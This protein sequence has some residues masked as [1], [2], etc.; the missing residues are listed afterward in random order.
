MYMSGNESKKKLVGPWQTIHGV[1]WIIGIYFLWTR[2][3]WWPGLL[4]LVGIS[5]LYEAIL[6]SFVPGAYEEEKPVAA[7]A[8]ERMVP[9][10]EVIPPPAAISTAP[11]Q[12][13]RIDLLPQVCPGCNAPV[14]SY[15]LKW[16]GVQ[17]ANCAYCGTNL[18]MNKA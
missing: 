6:R 2:G 1:I 8:P 11:V 18:P 9:P 10:A 17:S 7:N 4:I 13:H 3:W 12:E 16:T 14:R 5:F 15:E